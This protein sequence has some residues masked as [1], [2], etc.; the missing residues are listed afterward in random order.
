[1]EMHGW[2]VRGHKCVCLLEW[3]LIW[4]YSDQAGA[5]GYWSL[6]TD[7]KTAQVGVGR[8]QGDGVSVWVYPRASGRAP[9]A[10]AGEAISILGACWL[11]VC[12]VELRV[13]WCLSGWT[14]A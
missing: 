8:Y 1:M 7:G 12:G 13:L 6:D 11:R 10:G 3:H 5:H 9:T 2:E 4:I 14:L